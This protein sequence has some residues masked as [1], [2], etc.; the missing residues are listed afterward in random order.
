MPD[1]RPLTAIICDP[2]SFTRSA[3]AHLAREAGFDVLAE[4]TSSVD[5][6]RQVDLLEPS[7]VVIL[8]EQSGLTG[9]DAIPELRAT[10]DLAPEVVLL[11]SDL[12][13]KDRAIE[14]GAFGV[15]LR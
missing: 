7:L 5:A 8:H 1:A 9:L 13:V 12:S 14:R 10:G 2:D 3:A 6:A 11:T 4:I 15:A